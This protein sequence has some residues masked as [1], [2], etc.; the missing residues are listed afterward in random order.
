[1]RDY[2]RL[3]RDKFETRDIGYVVRSLVY[4][5]DAES[6]PDIRMLE[7]LSWQSLK[8][9]MGKWVKDLARIEDG[10]AKK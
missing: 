5:E 10:R 9:D 3:Y 4:F 7:S 8:V 2:L 6:E 1:M